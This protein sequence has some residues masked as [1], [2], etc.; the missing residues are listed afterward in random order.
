MIELCDQY[1][2]KTLPRNADQEPR[3]MKHEVN[4]SSPEYADQVP[5]RIKYEVNNTSQE[6][7][8]QAGEQAY[9]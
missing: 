1:Y 3:R 6:L 4:N 5:R 2:Y 7:R 9:M 8:V